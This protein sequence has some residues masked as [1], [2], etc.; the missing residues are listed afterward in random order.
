MSKDH[1]RR[2]YTRRRRPKPPP[3]STIPTTHKPT[4]KPETTIEGVVERIAYSNEEN[5]WS[6]V[7]LVVRGR[8]KVTAVGNLLGIQPGET[9]RLT[10]RWVRNRKWGDQLEVSS[11]LTVQPSTFV[12]IERYLSSGLVK[13]IGKTMAQRLVQHFGLDTLDVIDRHPERLTEVEGVGKVRSAQIRAAWQ[14]QRDIRGVMVFLQSH[15]VS[16]AHAVKI[17]KRYGSETIALLRENPYRLAAEVHGIGFKSADKIARDLGLEPGSPHRAEAGVLHVLREATDEGHVYVPR[18]HLALAAAELL[19]LGEGHVEPAIARLVERGELVAVPLGGEAG[20]AIAGAALEAAERGVAERLHRLTAQGML[21]LRLDVDRALAWFE[22]SEGFALGLEQRRAL[23]QAI[24]RKVLVITGGPGTGKTTLV[25]GILAILSKKGLKIAL[26]A[27]TGR[28]AKRLSEATGAEA[29][30]VHRLLEYQPQDRGFARGSQNPLSIDLLVVDEA[31]MLDV[32]LTH[33]LLR[34][35]PERARVIFVGDVDQLP[36]VGPGRVLADLIDSHVIDVVRL[37]EIFRQANESL[38]IVNAHRVRVG[39]MPILRPEDDHG[40]FFF[41]ERSDPAAIL[42]TVKQLV[43]ERIPRGFT[44]DPRRDIQVLSPMQ[45][46]LLGAANLNAELQALLN[47]DGDAITRGGRLLRVGDR[48]MQLRNNYD[49]DV[50][51][52]DLGRLVRLDLAE[53][54]AVV[55]YDGREVSYETAD[56]D[57]LVLAYACSIHKAQGSEYPCVVIPLHT[58]HYTL[59]QRN[60][61]YT[62]LTRGQRLVV[63]VGSRQALEI[64]VE[65]ETSTQRTTLLARRLRE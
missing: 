43:A 24:T 6:V 1:S 54:R 60:L 27:P 10:G 3:P 61:L 35:V 12:G 62:A 11:F 50:Y 29:K 21:P 56:L 44:F 38:I 39:A 31:S 4:M 37:A 13:G 26:A 14:E 33:H 53:Q 57:E 23:E 15:G 55:D 22:Q 19:E 32:V 41:F 17:Y 8:G 2:F 63:I 64:A 28:A 9:L 47:P 49:L 20:E 25:R 40:D 48:V 46:G 18:K 7:R 16:T 42:A 52:G 59:L 65:T 45:R 5:A 58:Q 36:S 34:A 51:N 30:T